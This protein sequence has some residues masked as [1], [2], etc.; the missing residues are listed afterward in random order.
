MEFEDWIGSFQF[1]QCR[2]R[3]FRY[4]KNVRVYVFV[5]N[6]CTCMHA[7]VCMCFCEYAHVNGY[8]NVSE[9]LH[10]GCVSECSG[11]HIL[12]S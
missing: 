4:T 5:Q 10:P 1:I 8:S 3:K 6:V 2:N 9:N 11:M 12:S 7:C